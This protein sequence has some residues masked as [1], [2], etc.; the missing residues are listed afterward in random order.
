[1]M[2]KRSCF[3]CQT[4]ETLLATGNPQDEQT[5]K[6]IQAKVRVY[7]NV[8]DRENPENGPVTLGFGKGIHEDLTA[9]RADPDAGGDFTHP[10]SGYDIVINRTG[11]GKQTE[12][13]VIG[14]RRQSPLAPDAALMQN[15][16]DSQPNLARLSKVPSDQEIMQAV[17]TA[18]MGLG[19]RPAPQP[20]AQTSKVRTAEDD[21]LEVDA[22]VE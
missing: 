14:S 9:L 8:I 17:G 21:A 2:S 6:D 12:Y 18:L 15:W 22:T 5:G 1:M 19:G 4:A 10:E 16:I 7:A 13:K 11:T 20:Q 3:V